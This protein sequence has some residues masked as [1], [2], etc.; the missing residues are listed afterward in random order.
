MGVVIVRTFTP[1]RVGKSNLAVL[2]L[3]KSQHWRSR[4]LLVG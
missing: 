4:I 1:L 2:I 3:A